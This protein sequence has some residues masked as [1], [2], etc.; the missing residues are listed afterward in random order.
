MSS[1][2]N[3]KGV[4]ALIG[5]ILIL[6]CLMALIL[7]SGCITASKD[8][9][10]EVTSTPVPTTIATTIPT[11]TPQI[12]YIT[13]TPTPAPVRIFSEWVSGER[14]MGELFSY[15]RDNVQGLKDM[16]IST[17]MYGYKILDSYEWMSE[18][19]Q[20]Y[21]EEYPAPGNK[22]V[23]AYIAQWEKGDTIED[24]A[25]VWGFGQDHYAIQY[26]DVVYAADPTYQPMIRIKEL[27][28]VPDYGTQNYIRPYG[29]DLEYHSDRNAT[30]NAGWVALPRQ[31]IR[32]GFSNRWD[33]FIIY[34][35]PA[36]AQPK[37]LRL[38][39]NGGSFGS[40]Q[41]TFQKK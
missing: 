11:P 18:Q 14:N 21:F 30:V 13:V 15:R 31:W 19:Y 26:R 23:I 41:W 22:F 6:I 32:M 9:Y 38:L 10:K 24:D 39:F 28:S 29:Y 7:S 4:C 1:D 2:F 12:I 27:E 35:I 5:L 40:A 3:Y 20:R 33:G 16:H 34:Q 36:S 37:D 25:S 8:L 17:V